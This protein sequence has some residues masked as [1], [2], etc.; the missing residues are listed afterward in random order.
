M[1]IDAHVHVWAE[2]SER[3]PHYRLTSPPAVPIEQLMSTMKE[4][5]VAHA[6]LV[7]PSLYGFDNSHIVDCFDRYPGR[8]LGVG[9]VDVRSMDVADKLSYWVGERGIH[10]IRLMPLA[11]P[12]GGLL[13]QQGVRS[14]FELA[15]HFDIPISL[16]VAPRHLAKV[17]SLVKE[18]PNTKLIIEHLGRPDDSEKKLM[19]A[20]QQ[21]L[22]IASSPS[23]YVKLSGLHA[24]SKESYPYSDTHPILHEI[25]RAFGSQRMLWGSDFP[26]VLKKGTYEEIIVLI[27]QRLSFLTVE[28]QERILAGT[29]REL[30]KI[31]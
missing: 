8:L 25:W 2:H 19:E 29:A 15:A 26:G 4:T 22:Q 3:Y 10:G 23:V 16:L 6:I 17:I 7:Q 28:D 11:D 27:Q 30:W 12:E 18:Y 9:M 5:G 24:I 31:P 13:D 21:L 20:I 14:V 1:I